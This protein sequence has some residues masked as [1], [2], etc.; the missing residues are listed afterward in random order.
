VRKIDLGVG[1]SVELRVD[2]KSFD[3]SQADE[4]GRIRLGSMDV[5]ASR[6]VVN[7]ARENGAQVVWAA[8][9]IESDL[10][11][12]ISLN[13]FD[14]VGINPARDFLNKDILGSSGFSF[15]FKRSLA[16]KIVQD[17]ELLPSKEKNELS[18]A[19]RIIEGYRNAFAHGKISARN[20]EGV[21]EYFSGDHK[22]DLLT[23]AYW[24][25]L[26]KDFAAARRLL[27]KIIERLCKGRMPV[28][29]D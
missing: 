23:N 15:S 2:L 10:K 25:E 13:M 28:S 8:L 18:G 9:E 11:Q 14:P 27:K 6:T 17:Q 3:A 21:L 1:F 5:E 7:T 4:N 12:I 26:E 19:L 24:D 20:N 22:E 29:G 16:Q